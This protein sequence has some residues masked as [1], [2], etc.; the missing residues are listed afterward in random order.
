[1]ILAA[2]LAAGVS[3]FVLQ[4][5]PNLG[6]RDITHAARG[7]IKVDFTSPGGTV[8]RLATQRVL[9]TSA[10]LAW[11]FST[12]RNWGESAAGAW[13][14]TVRDRAVGTTGTLNSVTP[15]LFGS[16]PTSTSAPALTS[17]TTATTASG[18]V[19]SAFGCQITVTNAPASYGATGL[20]AGLSVN[21]LTGFISG[22]VATAGTYPFTVSATN[23]F[24]TGSRSVTLT[25]ATNLA[26]NLADALDQPSLAWS[27]DLS[28]PWTR[29]AGAAPTTHDGVDAARSATIGDNGSTG[30]SLIASGPQVIR[31][32]WKVSSEVCFDFS[33][34]RSRWNR[35]GGDQRHRRLAAAGLHHPCGIASPELDV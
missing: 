25:L 12:V 20:P 32:W 10:D 19:G 17:A 9:D 14:L 8:S 23:A 1:M 35:A 21:A 29:V 30:F 16:S 6:W 24:G 18:D 13:T 31:F 11:T 26:A 3:A 28:K 15:S 4:A 33:P 7:S 27:L 2:P 5:N 34:L 22:K